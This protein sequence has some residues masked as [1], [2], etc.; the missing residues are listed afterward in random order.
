MT[1][2]YPNRDTVGKGEIARFEQFLLFPQCIQKKNQISIFK[3]HLLCRLHML[4]IWTGLKFCRWVKM[5]KTKDNSGGEKLITCCKD[6]CT[7]TE[8]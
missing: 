7:M 2:R 5:V 4:S 8:T 1:K 3:S 6:V